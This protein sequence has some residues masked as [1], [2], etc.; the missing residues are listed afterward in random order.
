VGPGA[1]VGPGEHELAITYN[2]FRLGFGIAPNLSLVLGYE[3]AGT[4]SV[5][6]DSGLNSWLKQETLLF[7]LQYHFGRGFYVRGAVGEGSVT[8]TTDFAHYSGG[9]GVALSGALG[10][11]FYQSHHVALALDLNASNTRYS[12]ESWQT[13]GLNLALSFF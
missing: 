1:L 5:N 8:E 9:S 10:Y 12:T 13:A 6:P 4:N 3:G 7:G 11:E 2:L